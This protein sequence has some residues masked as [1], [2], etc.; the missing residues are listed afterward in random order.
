MYITARADLPQRQENS[1]IAT[2]LWGEPDIGLGMTT[3]SQH[4][5]VIRMIAYRTIGSVLP[6]QCGLRI[7]AALAAC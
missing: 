4:T 5:Y 1:E 2:V 3:D 7:D 6:L